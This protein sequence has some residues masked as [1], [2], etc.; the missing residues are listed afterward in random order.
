MFKIIYPSNDATLYE[1]KPTYNTGID[2]ILEVGKHLTVAVTSSHSLSRTLL[3]F[4]YNKYK[5]H[6]LIRTKPTNNKFELI[7]CKSTI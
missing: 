4:E 3:K 5:Q 2:E 7:L 6:K 1:G